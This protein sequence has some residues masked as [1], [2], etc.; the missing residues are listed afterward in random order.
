M[1]NGGGILNFLKNKNLWKYVGKYALVLFVCFGLMML[2]AFFK[3]ISDV[4][5]ATTSSLIILVIAFDL[6]ILFL[7]YEKNL[8]RKEVAKNSEDIDEILYFWS[9]KS[10]VT[11]KFIYDLFSKTE[12][13]KSMAN[14]ITLKN[15]VKIACSG[16]DINLYLFKSYI[17][18]EL[19]NS[20]RNKF[21]SAILVAIIGVITTFITKGALDISTLSF[22]HN[23]INDSTGVLNNSSVIT[24]IKYFTFGLLTFMT[25]LVLGQVITKT[26][27]RLRLISIVVDSCIMELEKNKEN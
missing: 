21:W 20:K 19:K 26:K 7:F 11:G 6:F 1:R 23:F 9:G 16:D 10:G 25:F 27:N 5:I 15:K 13:E 17:E 18:L 8:E 4:I 14:L 22:L 24:Y 12:P 2:G 3:E